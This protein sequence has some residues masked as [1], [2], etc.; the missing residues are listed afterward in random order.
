MMFLLRTA[1]WVSVVLAL[2]P[3]FAPKQPASIKTD[4]EPAQAITAASA[5]VQDLSEFCDRQ[6]D[7]CAA[8]GQFASA[9]GQRTQEGAKILYDMIGDR[10]ARGDRASAGATAER[11]SSAVATPSQNT[12]TAADLV[13]AWRGARQSRDIAPRH[14]S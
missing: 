5:T 6:R 11:S 3:S 4:F 7:A 10:F 13:P 2:L 1:F 14:P 9:F 8:G 12:L